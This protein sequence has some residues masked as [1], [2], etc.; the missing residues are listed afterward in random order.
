M[1]IKEFEALTLRDCLRQVRQTLG[2]EAVILETRKLRKGGFLGWGARDAVRIVAGTGITVNDDERRGAAGRPMAATKSRPDHAPDD[3]AS[4]HETSQRLGRLVQARQSVDTINPDAPAPARRDSPDIATFLARHA[5]ASAAESRSE[6]AAS[7]P[8]TREKLTRLESEV[9]EMRAALTTLGEAHAV[10]NPVHTTFAADA[11]SASAARFPDLYQRLLDADVRE[12][13]AVEL[14]ARLPDLGRWTPDVRAAMAE[15]CLRDL[16]S[17]RIRATGPLNL[18]GE[19]PRVIA[20]VGPT[21][22]GKTTTIAKLSAQCALVQKKRVGLIT[23][24]T[25]RIAAVEQLKSYGQIIGIPVEVVHNQADI[26]AALEKLSGCDLILIDTAGRSQKNVMQVGELKSLVEAAQCEVH[27]VLAASTRERDLL[28]QV[29]RF[30]GA[31][32]DSLLFTKLD[33]TLTCGT[34]FN[35]AAQT[36]IAVSYL[37]TGQKVPEDIEAA[38]ADGIAERVL[39]QPAS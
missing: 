12:D 3:S 26:G 10:V 13:L 36:G 18:D 9:R 8:E 7:E 4:D 2:P 25:Y 1:K 31:R 29:T 6:S 5:A 27:L 21:G 32:V 38:S 24:D 35:V 17:A 16:M 15:Q 14:V 20:L 23:M 22:V 19:T 37:A 33:E 34:L 39:N 30:S 28:D 11:S